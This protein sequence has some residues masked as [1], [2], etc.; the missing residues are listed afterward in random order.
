VAKLL[1]EGKEEKAAI[2]VE[3]IIRCVIGL[4]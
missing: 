1:G 4:D 2:K 3:A